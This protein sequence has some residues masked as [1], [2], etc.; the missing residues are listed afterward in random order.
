[1]SGHNF[2]FSIHNVE[3]KP[4][5]PLYRPITNPQERK[6]VALFSFNT[7]VWDISDKLTEEE[8]EKFYDD[9]NLW[10]IFRSA[11]KEDLSGKLLGKRG[12]DIL[13]ENEQKNFLEIL[14]EKQP[15]LF[16]IVSEFVE[17]LQSKNDIKKIADNFD[18]KIE[19]WHMLS[20][21]EQVI[22]Y[23][24]SDLN[25]DNFID[26]AK[27]YKGVSLL[28]EIYLDAQE[29]ADE[30]IPDE[31]LNL[32]EWFGEN[33]ERTEEKIKQYTKSHENYRN[34]CIQ[35]K[36]SGLKDLETLKEKCFE[37]ANYLIRQAKKDGIYTK[38]YEKAL[39]QAISN[40]DI[41]NL[42]IYTERF[43][44][45][46]FM[47][48]DKEAKTVNASKRAIELKEANGKIDETFTQGYTGDCWFLSSLKS[49]CSNETFL[50]KINNMITVNEENGVI[51][52]ITVN[53]H[54][55]DYTIDYENIKGANEYATGDLDVRALEIAVNQYMHENNLGWG[56]ITLGWKEK[57]AYTLLFEE[58]NVE[59]TEY[60]A[61]ENEREFDS[62][63]YLST[64]KE[65]NENNAIV[66]SLG[67][68]GYDIFSDDEDKLYAEDM[69]G[70]EVELKFSHAYNYTKIDEKY[71]YFTDPHAPEKELRVPQE[72]IGKIFD[73]ANIVKLKNNDDLASL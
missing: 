52:S 3:Q 53:L 48:Q 6:P 58:D 17:N 18:L 55:K 57:E 15:R 64:L 62:E 70:N 23:S 36:E 14:K 22:G 27:T 43:H 21:N 9:D 26:V 31:E 47:Y 32:D 29:R 25:T 69:D 28:Y 41:K 4:Q 46:V 42:A 5:I 63:K 1:M 45:R 13:N 44:A 10:K 60:F 54:G 50:E 34:S 59:V 40:D 49:M 12:D 68:Y 2:N 56:D 30:E 72:R 19:D 16:E 66:S 20:D 8:Q 65:N 11:D 61:D 35:T 37:F 38:D 71:L 73:T 51:K 24:L 7:L 67:I 39:E 33:E